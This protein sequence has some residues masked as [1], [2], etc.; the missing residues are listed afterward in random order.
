MINRLVEI[1]EQIRGFIKQSDLNISDDVF[2]TEVMTTYRG[3]LASQSRPNYKL[4]WEKKQEVKKA[5]EKQI[6]Y[7]QN[8]ADQKGKDIKISKDLTYIEA[9]KMIEEL[10]NG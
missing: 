6:A 9:S 1:G 10:K 7:I 3:E 5:S 2:L 8:L 4:D